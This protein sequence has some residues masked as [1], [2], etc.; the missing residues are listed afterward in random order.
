[1]EAEVNAMLLAL[2][3]VVVSWLISDDP[4][5]DTADRNAKNASEREEAD[6]SPRERNFDSGRAVPASRVSFPSLSAKDAAFDKFISWAKREAHSQGMV[7]D[8]LRGENDYQKARQVFSDSDEWRRLRLSTLARDEKCLRCGSTD[9]LQADHIIPMVKRPD[10]YDYA[11]N[12]QT[13]CGPCNRWKM[14]KAIDYRDA[15]T[16]LPATPSPPKPAYN[17]VSIEERRRREQAMKDKQNLSKWRRANEKRVAQEVADAK[18]RRT[19]GPDWYLTERAFRETEKLGQFKH[20]QAGPAGRVRLKRFSF[21]S[22]AP[23]AGG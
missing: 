23:G 6:A 5:K 1:M 8:D 16:D 9:N 19:G 4:K 12:L 20:V 11:D 3:A 17:V 15:A 22:E 7:F 2:L 13:L 18:P 21:L 14:V 10:L